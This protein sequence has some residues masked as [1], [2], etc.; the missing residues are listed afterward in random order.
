MS[1]CT[2]LGPSTPTDHRT[3]RGGPGPDHPAA[4][5]RGAGDG[6]P[7]EEGG[8]AGGPI[9]VLH[10]ATFLNAVL[11]YALGQAK[12]HR[13]PLSL[14]CVA[15]DRLSAIRQLHG[16]EVADAAVRRVAETVGATLR[17]S[18]VVARLDDDRII[19]VL[20]DAAAI[21]A[22]R[23][24]ELIRGAIEAAGA[25]SPTMPTLTASI[26]MASYPAHAHDALSLIDAADAAMVRAERQ[27]RNR[28]ASAAPG[29]AAPT[30]GVTQCA[31]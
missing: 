2:T 18:D 23:V 20:P 7:A 13:E 30:L 6:R 4:E 9:A 19:A 24:A 11:P 16:D 25:A 3:P 22:A 1:N 31:G 27:G 14:L 21:H 8:G 5:G 29:S 15:V 12:R 17:A 10:D 28:V 26:G